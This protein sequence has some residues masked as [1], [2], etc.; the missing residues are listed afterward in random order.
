MKKASLIL[1]ITFIV[2][3]QF[4]GCVNGN[5]NNADTPPQETTEIEK[6]TENT[7]PYTPQ[8]GGET[9]EYFYVISANENGFI[10]KHNK[11]GDV[12]VEFED[13]NQYFGLFDTVR[14]EYNLDSIAEESGEIEADGFFTQKYSKIITDP[15]NVRESKM[16]EPI[17][18]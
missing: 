8:Y 17:I 5:G 1:I 12:F 2:F 11:L 16:G 7:S 9:V 14:V 10:G 15:V 6:V 4:S 13:A 3:T 18:G